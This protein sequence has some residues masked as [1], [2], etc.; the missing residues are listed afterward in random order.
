MEK[1]SSYLILIAIALGSGA[2]TIRAQ[3]P[4]IT[5]GSKVRVSVM[6]Q[7]AR[8]VGIVQEQS[9]DSLVV[10]LSEGGSRKTI[11]L[12]QVGKLETW[13][14]RRHPVGRGW[15]LGTG[16][17]ALAGMLVAAPIDPPCSGG[18]WCIGPSDTGEM[19]VVGL[20]GGAIVGG[21]V[22]AIVGAATPHGWRSFDLK[23]LRPDRAGAGMGLSWRLALPAIR[24]P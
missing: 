14:K 18:S 20:L 4:S 24:A 12:D 5:P 11:G 2:P 17:G 7:R 9:A 16:I 13:G 15:A 1:S 10:A 19:V 21:L 22:G 23:V 3:T 6:G 8:F